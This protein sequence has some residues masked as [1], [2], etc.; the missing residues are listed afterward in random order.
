MLNNYYILLIKKT[1]TNLFVTILNTNNKVIF[2][3]SLGHSI[4]TDFKASLTNIIFRC[5]TK[6]NENFIKSIYLS[7]KH[8]P[9]IYLPYIISIIQTWK[10]EILYINTSLNVPHNGC[11]LPHV[12]RKKQNEKTNVD[13]LSDFTQV[14]TFVY[15]KV[16]QKKTC[17]L[18]PYSHTYSWK[19]N[20]GIR[21]FCTGPDDKYKKT[22]QVIPPNFGLK[23]NYVG[24]THL[25]ELYDSTEIPI[26]VR[27]QLLQIHL[28]GT[29][30]PRIPYKKQEYL[31]IMLH[32]ARYRQCLKKDLD[33]LYDAYLLSFHE[34][35][36]Y[37]EQTGE[38]FDIYSNAPNQEEVLEAIQLPWFR[39]F[40]L[41]ED[42]LEIYLTFLCYLFGEPTETQIIVKTTTNESKES[43]KKPKDVKKTG[44]RKVWFLFKSFC[45]KVITFCTLFI[46]LFK[47]II[48]L[49]KQLKKK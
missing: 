24:S 8:I 3:E 37:L 47:M 30:H 29:P 14:N 22:Y 5:I 11:R 45:K 25:Y 34:T 2:I 18:K 41:E 9:D 23:K 28:A 42:E 44:L 26:E 1:K 46:I 7:L 35:I 16:S 12:S 33:I 15:F 48:K 20:K 27:I 4:T 39:R 31:Y 49:M 36:N 43:I 6:I 40:W 10:I 17:F 21:C 38:P 19:L 32:D 13:S